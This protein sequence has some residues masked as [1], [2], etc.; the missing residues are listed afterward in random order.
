MDPFS[1]RETFIHLQPDTH[2]FL[3]NDGESTNLSDNIDS[4]NGEHLPRI[5][6][7][8]EY[9]VIL[10]DEHGE[11]RLDKEGNPITFICRPPS[12][13]LGHVFLTKPV[14]KYIVF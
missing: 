2:F 14:L 8:K 1:T 10:R 12:N 6:D 11:P 13:L 3:K 5:I 9:K 4:K 7:L